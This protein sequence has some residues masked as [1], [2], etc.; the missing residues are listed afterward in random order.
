MMLSNAAL[1]K[2]QEFVD[3]VGEEDPR[4]H[5]VPLTPREGPVLYELLAIGFMRHAAGNDLAFTDEGVRWLSE[6]GAR[7]LM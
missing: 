3:L 1:R 7:K 2:M 5:L 4:G 6:H